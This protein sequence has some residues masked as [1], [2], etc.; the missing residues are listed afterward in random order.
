MRPSRSALLGLVLVVA[1]LFACKK[2]HPVQLATPNNQQVPP[3]DGGSSHKQ[4]N[5]DTYSIECFGTNVDCVKD[6]ASVCQA[7]YDVLA[8][9]EGA[10]LEAGAAPLAAPADA[11]AAPD[12]A[13]QTP[14]AAAPPAPL[15][16]NDAGT[17]TPDGAVRIE[18]V[19]KCKK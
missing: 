5:A 18:M 13:S 2:N 15:A 14:D 1:A 7:G 19:V 6:A 17:V 3:S 8:T 10:P 12:A 4:I 9:S 16:P 11:A